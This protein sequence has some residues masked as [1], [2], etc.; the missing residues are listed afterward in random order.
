MVLSLLLGG[1][2]L[3]TV[4]WAGTWSYSSH[5]ARYVYLII[6]IVISLYVLIFKKGKNE[7]SKGNQLF[8][9]G[10]KLIF[11]AVIGVLL[12]F[13]AISRNYPENIIDLSSPFKS[14]NYLVMQGGNSPITN[15]FHRSKRPQNYALDIIKLYPYGNRAKG[16]M[17]MSLDQY[18]IYGDTIYSP[19]NGK[20]V[21]AV[22]GIIENIPP[23]RNHQ[24]PLGNF[25]F[26]Q[27]EEYLLGFGHLIKGSIK[28]SNGQ[29]I[30]E[31]Q[32]LGRVG[33]SGRTIEP[34][35]HM[36]IFSIM[37][38]GNGN[39]YYDPIP[40]SINGKKLMLNDRF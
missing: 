20:V 1:I 13:I 23:I 37:S 35:L 9:S 11:I 31:G 38:D 39:N 19:V 40:F 29:I 22:D 3:I 10:I 24:T 17:P 7:S 33:N 36:Q 30:K 6:W 21:R 2:L 26:I 28:V 25:I 15:F 8:L 18:A 14:G 16:I 5:Y 27:F 32:P 34:H 12:Y 4:F